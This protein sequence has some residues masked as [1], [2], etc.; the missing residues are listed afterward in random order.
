MINLLEVLPSSN[1]ATSLYRGRLPLLRLQKQY[2]DKLMLFPHHS[3]SPTTWDYL[4][5]FDMVYM[6]RPGI[7]RELKLLLAAKRLNIPVIV[8]YDDLLCGIPADN[9]ACDSY[10]PEELNIIGEV[11]QNADIVT[12]STNGLKTHLSKKYGNAHK[13]KVIPNALCLDT[14]RST[15]VFRKS[16][17]ILWRGSHTHINDLMEYT[18]EII[19][20]MNQNKKWEIDFMGYDPF[21]ITSQISNC[22]YEPRMTIDK[23]MGILDKLN[24]SICIVPLVDIPFNRSKSNIAWI[25]S[26][27]AGAVCLAPDWEEW[28]KPG[29]I[30]YKNKA[31]FASKLKAMI[32]GEY[33]LSRLHKKSWQY[34]STHLSLENVNKSRLEIITH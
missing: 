22:G 18:P 12:L 30:T 19:E 25:E 15:P 1:D 5:L 32:S 9:P 33:D 2:P 8:D 10:G 13:M 7:E 27:Y 4:L 29:V 3:G 16:K 14:F 17:N 20:V 34:I 31:D 26:T 24:Y 21:F 28:Q 6:Q 11:I 23:Y